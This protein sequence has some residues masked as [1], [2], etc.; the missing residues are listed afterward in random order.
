MTDFSVAK[1][2]LEAKLR[3]LT[4]RAEE[5]EDDLSQPPVGDWG[6]NAVESEDDE[7]LEKVGGVTMQEM[8]QVKLALSQ[9][10]DG[11]YGVCMACGSSIKRE[12]LRAMPHA[13][14][15]VKCS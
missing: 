5:I 2:H 4:A 11:T 7:V 13:T 3:E 6:D 15:C 9:I 12:R 10:A 1:K 8:R 14:K